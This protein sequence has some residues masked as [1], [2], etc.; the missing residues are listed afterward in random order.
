MI[1]RIAVSHYRQIAGGQKIEL[2]HPAAK[3]KSAD[4]ACAAGIWGA[5]G[6]GK[7]A[8]IDALEWLQ[9]TATHWP[10]ASWPP[11]ARSATA[12][13][14]RVSIDLLHEEQI[15]RYTLAAEN[16]R[17][18][19]E[20]LS[21]TEND[22]QDGNDD[23]MLFEQNTGGI[24]LGKRMKNHPRIATLRSW[25]EGGIRS[26]MLGAQML[27]HEPCATLNQQIERIQFVRPLG[28][29]DRAIKLT[30]DICSAGGPGNSPAGIRRRIAAS[31]LQQ[32]GIDVGKGDRTPCSQ[33]ANRIADAGDGSLRAAAMAGAAAE[34]LTR[35]SLLAVDTIDAGV[36]AVWQQALVDCFMRQPTSRAQRAQL[37]FTTSSSDLL[38]TIARD[39]V[40]LAE[41]GTEGTTI[42]SLAEFDETKSESR[43]TRKRYEIGRYSRV[44]DPTPVALQL[45]CLDA[46]AA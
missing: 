40:W 4:A 30:V 22:Q 42:W 45:A 34:A 11:R 10:P 28:R 13:P 35:G 20:R 38:E 33:V 23:N 14:A 37:L 46:F 6:C 32:A 26:M 5:N 12:R 15:Y 8:L 25:T 31:L 44:P 16:E 39:Q 36:H 27:G 43:N 21:I 24:K 9:Q 1:T 19:L 41:H 29:I 18:V 17:I 3:H 7:S 2:I